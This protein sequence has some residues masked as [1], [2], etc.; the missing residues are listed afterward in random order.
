MEGFLLE[1]NMN[2]VNRIVA[3]EA[4]C[5]TLTRRQRCGFDW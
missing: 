1:G 5:Y 2:S 4:M 3:R